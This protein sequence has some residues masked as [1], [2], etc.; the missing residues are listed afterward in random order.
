MAQIILA[1][2]GLILLLVGSPFLTH[3][4]GERAA[5]IGRLAVNAIGAAC[6]IGALW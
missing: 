3:A 4:D 5:Q 6:L 1:G 2:F